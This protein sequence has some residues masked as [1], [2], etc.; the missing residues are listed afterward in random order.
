M[1]PVNNVSYHSDSINICQH[2]LN[3]IQTAARTA[4]P[5]KSDEERK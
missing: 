3:F 5:K 4:N 1:I 2:L